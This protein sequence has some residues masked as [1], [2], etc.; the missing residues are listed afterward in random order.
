MNLQQAGSSTLS[1][2][3]AGPLPVPLCV[4]LNKS[5][6][7]FRPLRCSTES[8]GGNIQ[9]MG[10]GSP[11]T[12]LWTQMA[13]GHVHRCPT[14]LMVGETRA[15]PQGGTCQDSRYEKKEK[16]K[17]NEKEKKKKKEERSAERM[18]KRDPSCARRESSWRSRYGNARRFLIKFKVKTPRGPAIARVGIDLDEVSSLTPKHAADPGTTRACTAQIH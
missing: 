11:S 14:P 2:E 12:F 10:R 16:R 6:S 8:K 17:N 13:H 1:S 15:E 7:S 18:W 5:F 9:K 3:R 4:K